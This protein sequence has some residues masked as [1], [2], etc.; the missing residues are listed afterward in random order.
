MLS[1][2]KYF[3]ATLNN[4]DWKLS[5][6]KEFGHDTTYCCCYSQYTM[7]NVDQRL[8]LMI[9]QSPQVSSQLIDLNN[10]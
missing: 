1:M 4:K 10:R 5:R 6:N 7:Y 8:S 3:I 2:K 9:N